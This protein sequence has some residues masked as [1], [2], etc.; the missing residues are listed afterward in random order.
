MATSS[1]AWGAIRPSLADHSFYDIKTI[2][3]LSGLDVGQLS[4]LVQVSGG[5]SGG[6]TKG[7]LMTAIDSAFGNMDV[8]DRLNFVTFVTEELLRRN[9]GVQEQLEEHLSRHGWGVVDNCL[10]LLE[11]FDPTGL[12]QLLDAPRTDLLKAA[13]RFRDGDLSG[14]ISAACGAVDTVTSAIYSECSLGDPT[15]ASFQERCSRALEARK[16]LSDIEGQL[17]ELAWDDTTLKTLSQN[18]KGALNQGAYVMQTLRSNMGDVHGTKPIL[19]PLV[20]DVLKWAE[21]FVR[22]LS[23]PCSSVI[24]R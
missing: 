15:R 4:H 19:K 6:A 14:A 3:G 23:S 5:M 7:Q 17:R 22:T 9:P 2:V 10:V 11:L 18:F 8:Q 13:Q 21:L 24:Q 1:K 16:V 20:F 12:A